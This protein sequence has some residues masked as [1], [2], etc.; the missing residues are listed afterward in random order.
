MPETKLLAANMRV[1]GSLDD[2]A[3]AGFVETSNNVKGKYFNFVQRYQS[4]VS[5]NYAA[6]I[7]LLH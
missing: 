4:K 2:V 1:S 6:N 5:V 3:L 7:H